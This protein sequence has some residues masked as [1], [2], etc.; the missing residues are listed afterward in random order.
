M[1]SNIEKCTKDT[2]T[3]DLMPAKEL[4]GQ[5][6]GFV[7]LDKIHGLQQPIMPVEQNIEGKKTRMDS[8]MPT[9]TFC[10]TVVLIFGVIFFSIWLSVEVGMCGRNIWRSGLF[11]AHQ[12]MAQR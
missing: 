1:I 9:L 6:F 7:S 3:L 8:L 12:I 11:T 10:L 4:I 2:L 5:H